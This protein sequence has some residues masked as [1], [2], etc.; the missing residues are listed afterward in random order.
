MCTL[1]QEKREKIM[2]LV[3]LILYNIIIGKKYSVGAKSAREKLMP[4]Q[5]PQVLQEKIRNA[6]K[7]I[8]RDIQL[9]KSSKGTNKSMSTLTPGSDLNSSFSKFPISLKQSQRK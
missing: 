1:K 8:K 9:R 5:S 3:G 6:S 4:S 2:H 7:K